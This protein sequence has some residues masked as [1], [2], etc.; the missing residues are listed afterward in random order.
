MHVV[1]EP[2][3]LQKLADFPLKRGF[4]DLAQPSHKLE[5]FPAA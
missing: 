2:E 5:V 1:L 4:G 3:K